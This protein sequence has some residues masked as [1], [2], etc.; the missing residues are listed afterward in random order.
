MLIITNIS[1]FSKVHIT[2]LHFYKRSTLVPVF[3]NWKKPK[4]D[5][6]FYKK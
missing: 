2:P 4:E 6:H 5:F 1:H 3:V